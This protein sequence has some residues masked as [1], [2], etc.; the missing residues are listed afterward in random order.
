MITSKVN[1]HVQESVKTLKSNIMF[2]SVDNPIKTLILTSTNA[3]EGKSTITALLGISMAE[4]GKKTLIVDT[5]LRRPTLGNT[6]GK[7]NEKGLCNVL[8][9]EVTTEEAVVKTEYENLYFLDAGPIPPNPVEIIG[10]NQFDHFMKTA[11]DSFDIVIYDMAPVGLFIE[12]ALVA[13]KTDGVVLVVAQGE[14]DRKSAVEAKEQ[15]DRAHAKILGVVLN[16]VKQSSVTGYYYKDQG[17][18][19]YYDYYDEDTGEKREKHQKGAKRKSK[20]G[21][22]GF[23]K[24]KKWN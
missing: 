8:M 14:T 9:G 17:Y 11:K 7:R 19:G 18:Y 10:S 20:K 12:P 6:L 16:K 24:K 3:G 1:R 5:D 21:F 2:S 15:L 4:S 13:A 23:S 22:L